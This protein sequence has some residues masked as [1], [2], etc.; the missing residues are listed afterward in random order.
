M[1]NTAPNT[2]LHHL[3]PTPLSQ[4]LSIVM[5]ILKQIK[6]NNKAYA[7]GIKKINIGEG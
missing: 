1:R 3:S 5:H 4:A 2:F 7:Y 6:R